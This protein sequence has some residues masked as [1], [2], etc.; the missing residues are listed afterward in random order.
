MNFID[1]FHWRISM[2]F[3]MDAI[4]FDIKAWFKPKE[5]HFK[6]CEIEFFSPSYYVKI[7]RKFPGTRNYSREILGTHPKVS[8]Y[9]SVM[10]SWY[11]I[12]Q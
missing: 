1:E 10:N 3:S 12:T 9:E 8:N 7:S 5:K 6:N 11:V 2:I 4:F